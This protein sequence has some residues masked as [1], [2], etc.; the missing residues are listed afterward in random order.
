MVRKLFALL[1]VVWGSG[2]TG[3]APIHFVVSEI[4]T[5]HGDSYVLPLEDADDIAHARELILHGPSIGSSII[6]A[7][8]A[9]GPDGVNRDVLAPGEPL[10]SWHVDQFDGFADF[11]AEVLDGWPS[12]VEQ[13]VEG[14]IDNTNGYIGFWNYTVTAELA[15]IPVPGA[16]LL[17]VSGLLGVLA[18]SRRRAAG[19]DGAAR[20]RTNRHGARKWDRQSSPGS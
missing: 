11:T 1:L 10:W 4:N 9:R 6:V 3:A 19:N 7:H 16:T 13:D 14:W 2:P 15:A 20:Y 5:Q 12:F 17:F 18:S 8:I